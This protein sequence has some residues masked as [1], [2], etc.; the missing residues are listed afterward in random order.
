MYTT[1]KIHTNKNTNHCKMNTFLVL[2][3]T[4]KLKA[5]KTVDVLIFK[6]GR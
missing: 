4:S 3:T 5:K 2:L 1:Y 6:F